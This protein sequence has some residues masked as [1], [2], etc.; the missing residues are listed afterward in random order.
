MYSIWRCGDFNNHHNQW[1]HSS[2]TTHLYSLIRKK[3][4]FISLARNYGL[5]EAPQLKFEFE[6]AVIYDYA[7]GTIYFWYL[8]KIIL[9]QSDSKSSYWVFFNGF[10]ERTYCYLEKH[11]LQNLMYALCPYLLL[12]R[13]VCYHYYD[14]N[15]QPSLT[16]QTQLKM[17]D[18]W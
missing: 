12:K 3:H 18:K 4:I 7:L 15:I 11:F 17:C 5:G 1:S 14:K 10:K 2:T 8:L 13:L 6:L 9:T 16:K